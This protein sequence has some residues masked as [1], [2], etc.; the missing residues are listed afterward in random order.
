MA[1]AEALLARESLD[2]E[3]VKRIVDGLPIDEPPVTP[4][5][6][7]PDEPRERARDRSPLLPIVPK[8]LTQ[9]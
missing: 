1:I 9:E 7:P 2:G 4:P 5:P 3:Q 8:P 6:A